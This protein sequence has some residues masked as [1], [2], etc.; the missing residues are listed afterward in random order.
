MSRRF[1]VAC[2]SFCDAI[3]PL[4]KPCGDTKVAGFSFV[5]RVPSSSHLHSLNATGVGHQVQWKFSRQKIFLVNPST[6]DHTSAPV[7]TGW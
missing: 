2:G 1:P 4:G 5:S 7:Q 6:P 3:L